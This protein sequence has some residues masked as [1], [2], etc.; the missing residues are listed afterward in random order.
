MELEIGGLMSSK[1]AGIVSAEHEKILSAIKEICSDGSGTL[2]MITGFLSL[3]VI[4]HIKL[5]DK[6]LF[7]VD[8]FQ[9][10]DM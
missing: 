9:F 2:A 6:G 7:D 4:P 8:K 5:S 1:P 3:L 10:I